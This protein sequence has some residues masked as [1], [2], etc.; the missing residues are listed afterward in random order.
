MTLLVWMRFVALCVLA[1]LAV[2]LVW[3]ASAER[4]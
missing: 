2:G 3:A 1:V 4:E